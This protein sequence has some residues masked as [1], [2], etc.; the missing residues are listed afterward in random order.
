MGARVQ[1]IPTKGDSV[2]EWNKDWER[3]AVDRLGKSEFAYNIFSITPNLGS[4][5]DIT[6]QTVKS[7]FATPSVQERAKSLPEEEIGQLVTRQIIVRTL[8]RLKELATFLQG[9]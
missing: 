6:L 3:D 1:R 2:M 8:D 7:D 4:V 5:Y 9:E